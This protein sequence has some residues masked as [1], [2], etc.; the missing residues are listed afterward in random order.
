MST[1]DHLLY[2]APAWAGPRSGDSTFWSEAACLTKARQA[3]AH[4]M[5]MRAGSQ[6][7]GG[8]VDHSRCPTHAMASQHLFYYSHP[9]ARGGVNAAAAAAAAAGAAAGGLVVLWQLA[10]ARMAIDMPYSASSVWF[11]LLVI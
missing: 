7:R 11:Y 1:C 8:L 5:H 10:G 3:V 4:G 2:W 9:P 6:Q